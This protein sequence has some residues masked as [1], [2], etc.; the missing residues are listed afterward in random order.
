MKKKVI[1]ILQNIIDLNT[2]KPVYV[3]CNDYVREEGGICPECKGKKTFKYGNYEYNCKKCDGE[4]KLI[5]YPQKYVVKNCLCDTGYYP[6][7]VI[8]NNNVQIWSY[9]CIE[10]FFNSKRQAQ[11]LADKLN[12]EERSIYN[13]HCGGK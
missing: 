8:K 4:G 2:S 12:G 10:G 5:L 3:V 7:I 13:F 1:R 11:E 6:D 9:S